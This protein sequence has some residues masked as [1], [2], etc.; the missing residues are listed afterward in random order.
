MTDNE[1]SRDLPK[2]MASVMATVPT[3]VFRTGWAYLRMKKR[4]QK[5]SKQIEREF[6]SG[7]IPPEYAEK[8]AEQYASDLS[9]RK[10]M[11]GVDIP[12]FDARRPQ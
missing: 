5:A 8:L 10:M 2:I 7:G 6:V 3:L 9:V 12:F 1:T 4:A 11:R